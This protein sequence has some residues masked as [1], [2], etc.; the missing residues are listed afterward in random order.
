[1]IEK[2]TMAIIIFIIIACAVFFLCLCRI[3]AK[4]PPVPGE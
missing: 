4:M 3:A 1:M 2:Y